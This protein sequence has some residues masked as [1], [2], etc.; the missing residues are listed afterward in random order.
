VESCELALAVIASE[1]LA[2]IREETAEEAHD[3]NQMV[4]VNPENSVNKKVQVGAVLSPNRKVRSLTFSVSIR[5]SLRG[6][7]RICQAY[8]EKS[9]SMP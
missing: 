4:L 2:A 6:N 5:I 3:S 8:R 1:E 7:P 9:P